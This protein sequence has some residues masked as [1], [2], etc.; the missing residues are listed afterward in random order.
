MNHGAAVANRISLRVQF[1]GSNFRKEIGPLA[2]Q[3]QSKIRQAFGYPMT[4]DAY[5][6]GQTDGNL[7]NARVEGSYWG[8]GDKEYPYGELHEYHINLGGFV[9]YWAN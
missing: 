6:V 9:P 2:I 5:K 8:I 1:G 3:P 4:P 7:L